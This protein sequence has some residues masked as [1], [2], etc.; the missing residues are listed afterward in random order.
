MVEKPLG[1]HLADWIFMIVMLLG[2]LYQIIIFYRVIQVAPDVGFTTD[3]VFM[4]LAKNLHEHGVSGDKVAASG[5]ILPNTWRTP[6]F[7]VASAL[8]YAVFGPDTRWALV[9]NN[10]FYALA[11]ILTFFLGRRLHPWG[12]V[13]AAL[14]VILDPIYLY[15]INSVM[16]DAV[17]HLLLTWLLLHVVWML[18]NGITITRVTVAA[19]LICLQELARPA[20]MYLWI[21]LSLIIAVHLWRRASWQ[22]IAKLIGIVMVLHFATVG[23][24]SLRNYN[25]GSLFKFECMS[26]DHLLRFHFPVVESE[27]LSIS[28]DEGSRRIHERFDADLNRLT[29]TRE[30]E[31]FVGEANKIMFR[32]TFP[33]SLWVMIKMFPTLYIGFPPDFF[34]LFFSPEEQEHFNTYLR[35]HATYSRSWSERLKFVHFLLDNGYWLIIALG[36]FSKIVNSTLLVLAVVGAVKMVRVTDRTQRDIGIF[37]ALFVVQMTLISTVYG[38]ARYRLPIM[39]AVDILAFYAL[40]SFFQQRSKALK[41]IPAGQPASPTPPVSNNKTATSAPPTAT[42]G[43]GNKALTSSLAKSAAASSDRSAKS[44]AASSDKPAKSAAASSDRSAKSAAAS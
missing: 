23:L 11:V 18:Q 44:S 7:P 10:V 17:F 16:A 39:P 31:A 1:R 33:W 30:Q 14:F 36:L 9:M 43:T 12:G 21:I 35:D 37:L 34:T 15:T 13:F 41:A 40:W 29:T 22:H 42:P 20:G 19:I 32:E 26:G 6:L 24:W 25:A 27:R 28:V 3:E 5:E 4:K 38:M 2:F 8:V